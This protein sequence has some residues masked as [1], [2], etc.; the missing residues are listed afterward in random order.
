MYE[1]LGKLMS[2]SQTLK[3]KCEACGHQA[4]W[5]R[6]DAFKRFGMNASAFMIRRRSKCAGCGEGQRIAVWI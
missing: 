5:P 3:L 6:A 2:A 1:T 4:E